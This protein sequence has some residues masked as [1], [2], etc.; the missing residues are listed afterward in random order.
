M[1]SESTRTNT[2]TIGIIAAALL[3]VMLIVGVQLGMR[4]GRKQALAAIDRGEVSTGQP[5][6]VPGE[7]LYC[8]GEQ[9]RAWEDG[10]WVLVD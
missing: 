2:A 9:W 3:L 1:D 8:H 5:C 6:E 7:I 10:Q 4:E